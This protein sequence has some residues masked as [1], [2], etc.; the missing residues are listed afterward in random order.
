MVVCLN[1]RPK[2]L[3]LVLVTL[4]VLLAGIAF[5]GSALSQSNDVAIQ[6]IDILLNPVA[7]VTVDIDGVY[8]GVTDEDGML[9]LTDYTPG[10]HNITVSKEGYATR[11]AGRDL[12]PDA[13]VDVE[14]KKQE[15]GLGSD[16][17]TFVVLE[18]RVSRSKV[19]EASIFVDE[20]LIGKTNRRDGAL[21]A[22]VAPGNHTVTVYKADAGLLNNSTVFNIEPGQTYTLLM[23]PGGKTFSIFDSKLFFDSLNIILTRGMVVTIQLSIIA[24]TVG[25]LIGLAMGIGRTSPNMVFRGL[26]SIYVEGVRGLP[27]LLQLLFV[28]FGIPFMV[29]DLTG[30]QFNIDAFTACIVALAVNSGAYMAEIFKAGIEAVHKGQT[31]AARSLGM[32]QG[33]AMRYIIL[34]QAFKIVLP[35]LGNEFIALIKDSSIAMVIAVPE[36]LWWSKTIGAGAYNTFTPLLAAGMV[37]LCITI[38]LGRAVQYI[39]KKYNV[40]ARKNNLPGKKKKPGVKPEVPV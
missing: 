30:G 19:A 23:T 38:P 14:I 24:F 5:S 28:N 34:P 22:V 33:Q 26:S 9:Y 18:D 39:E 32:T 10:K 35:A 17:V 37:Y 20:Q 25:I 36:V 8:A 2:L 16:A 4:F 12:V 40:N 1:N 13:V 7:N 6:V 31:E 27:L 15:G 11:T 29:S 3:P 21:Q